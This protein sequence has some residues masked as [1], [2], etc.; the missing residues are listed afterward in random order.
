MGRGVHALSSQFQSLWAA[1]T[2]TKTEECPVCR[3]YFHYTR[4]LQPVFSLD[5]ALLD[6]AHQE[7]C[8][9]CW[10]AG[11]ALSFFLHL[12]GPSWAGQ[13]I[14]G[15]YFNPHRDGADVVLETVEGGGS[16]KT[17]E[18]EMFKTYRSRRR[19]D[20]GNSGGTRTRTRAWARARVWGWSLPRLIRTPT[21][22]AAA[23]LPSYIENCREARPISGF[24]GSEAAFE[25]I[26]RWFEACSAS[27]A[28]CQDGLALPSSAP[29]PTRLIDIRD[30]AQLRLVDGADAA[31]GHSYVCLSHRW[32][33]EA[34]MPRCTRATLD[35]LRKHIPWDSLTRTFQ[36]AILF[37]TAPAP[38][39]TSGSTASAS[40]K[41]APTTGRGRP[42][43]CA[44]STR[45]PS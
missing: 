39:A 9:G 20:D 34:K 27:H 21:S 11:F 19:V 6:P 28:A 23:A 10:I 30:K 24:T 3:P 5:P 35:A 18:L 31:A 38:C 22:S 25:T 2:A 37:T 44:P 1:W 40:S 43:S 14:T 29:M 26:F 13:E 15:F 12:V 17:V 45:G 42:S 32:G 41:T 8:H 4:K 7:R 33:E 16:R 36:E